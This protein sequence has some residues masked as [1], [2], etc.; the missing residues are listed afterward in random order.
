[1]RGGRVFALVACCAWGCSLLVDAGGLTGKAGASDAG[2]AA[3]DAADAGAAC[4]VSKPFGAPVL[5]GVS[6]S[7]SEGNP[8]LSP[9]ELTMVFGRGSG[10]G[11]SSDLFMA[12][13]ATR[14]DSFSPPVPLSA[15]STQ[16]ADQA[17]ALSDDG[18]TLV[19]SSSR[20]GGVGKSDLYRAVRAST[21]ETFG[22]V[23]LLTSA[24]NSTATETDPFLAGG[25]LWFSSD[26]LS[27]G[28]YD[29]FRA[30]GIDR[31]PAVRV[32]ELDTSYE[33]SDPTLSADGLTIYFGSDR[34]DAAAKG[35]ID[36]WTAHRASVG[37]AFDAPRPVAELNSAGDD[38]PGWISPDGCRFYFASDRPGGAGLMDIYFAERPR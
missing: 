10:S 25:E 24:I 5:M 1:M 31:G 34:P 3:S 11:A 14:F 4:D 20:D 17:P 32:D 19:F 21:R 22:T 36:I 26:R 37:S 33:E 30:P 8:R 38:A 35:G 7:L 12:T 29:I 16:S 6:S 9:D 27:P 13:R 28:V 15:V 23:T 2:L 18:L